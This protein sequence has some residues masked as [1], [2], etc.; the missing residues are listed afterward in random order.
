MPV[1]KGEKKP[2]FTQEERADIVERVCA[3]YESQNA[4]IESCCNAEGISGRVF[5]L[6]CAQ[7][8][9]YAERYKKAKVRAEESWFEE[10]LKPKAMRAAEMLLDVT[11]VIEEKADEVYWQG[12]QSKDAEGNPLIK[13]TVSKSWQLPNPAV[14]IFAMKAAIPD[15]FKDNVSLSGNITV[16]GQIDHTPEQAAKILAAIR[17]EL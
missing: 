2:E 7:Y 11:E 10:V 8:A 5:N 4:T 16:G 3:L 1:K 12:V 9:E 17:G 14:T 13:K 15:K 6:W